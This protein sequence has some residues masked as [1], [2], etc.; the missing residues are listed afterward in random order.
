MFGEEVL[1]RFLMVNMRMKLTGAFK[2][3]EFIIHVVNLLNVS[4]TFRGHLQGC[5]FR[6]V[7]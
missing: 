6:R 7:C 1:E 3:C 4:A 2:I 5:V